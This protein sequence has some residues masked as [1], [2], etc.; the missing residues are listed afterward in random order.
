MRLLHTSDWHLGRSFHGHSTLPQLR[1]V[2][3]AFPG[4]VTQHAVDLVAV[5]GD[6]F[7]HAAPAPEYY[8]V[9]AAAIRGIRDAGAEVVFISGNHDNATRLGFQA[10]W[11]A[12]GGVH[13]LT[14]ADAFRRPVALADEHGTVDVYGIPFLEPMLHRGLYPEERLRE[15]RTLLARV[16]TEINEQRAAR[17]NRSVVL[18][19]CFAANVG[20]NEE[21]AAEAVAAGRD[22]VWDLTSGGV[23]LVP[24]HVFTGPDYVA[25][26]HLHGRSQ[27]APQIRYSGAPLHFSFSEADRP[28]G[29]WLVELGA[30]GFEGAEWV[31]LPIPRPLARLRGPLEELLAAEEHAVHSESWVEATL[32]DAVRPIDAMRRL[33]ERFPH[34]AR[35]EFAPEGATPTARRSYASRVAQR[36]DTD[37][38]DEFLQHVRGG[39]GLAADERVVV[40]EALAA[41]HTDTRPTATTG[42]SE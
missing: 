8:E 16:M 28:R 38:I 22:L 42:G 10:E 37:V 15:H 31:P 1:E 34:C 3:A 12:L 27:L 6:V 41:A 2:L 23:D 35:I 24:A 30:T 11:A 19:H 36:S 40:A 18:S 4:L 32:T 5:A 9:L 14:R 13:M 29:A 39:E 25:L 33:R 26:G 20:A 7:D 21:A 17:G